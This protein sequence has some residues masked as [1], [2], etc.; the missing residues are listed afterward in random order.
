MTLD[1]ARSGEVQGLAGG[2][3][4]RWRRQHAA[5]V[6]GFAAHLPRRRVDNAE[7]AAALGVDPRWITRACGTF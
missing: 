7:L 6:L 3:R 5:S 2:G 1:E 4:A